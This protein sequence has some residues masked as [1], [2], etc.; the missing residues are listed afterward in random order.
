DG[1]TNLIT[2]VQREQTRL[3]AR[4][5]QLKQQLLESQQIIEQLK[6]S[7]NRLKNNRVND[8]SKV[9][10]V[11]VN[12]KMTSERANNDQIDDLQNRIKHFVKLLEESND[13]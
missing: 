7:L 11:H 12:E 1:Y 9:T 10:E 5:D 8:L 4:C 13:K 2:E 3:Q 6:S